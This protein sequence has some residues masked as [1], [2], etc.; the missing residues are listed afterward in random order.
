MSA[1]DLSS[2]PLQAPWGF[3]QR[4][5]PWTWGLCPASRAGHST[6]VSPT[7]VFPQGHPRTLGPGVCPSPAE[8]TPPKDGGTRA[9]TFSPRPLGYGQRW[10]EALQE[11]STEEGK[12]AVRRRRAEAPR[13]EPGRRRRAA[14]EQD[15][16]RWPAGSGAAGEILGDADGTSRPWGLEGT[17]DR[18]PIERLRLVNAGCPAGSPSGALPSYCWDLLPITGRAQV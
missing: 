17:S 14:A 8:Q 1:G 7:N 12:S 4:S 11:G 15:G 2:Q 10:F 6:P 13:Q 9:S 16:G 18:R 5:S 3:P